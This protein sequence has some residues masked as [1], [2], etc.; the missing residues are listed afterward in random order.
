MITAWS[1]SRW[2]CYE[3]CPLKARFKFVDKL[4]EPGSP[5]MDRGTAI[6]QLAQDY[7]EGKV[8]LLPKELHPFK[9]DFRAL[10]KAHALCE[11]E[12][13]FTSSW[14]PTTWFG[15]DAWLR[16]K[17][18]VLVVEPATI[19]VIDHKT[20]KKYDDHQGQLSLYALA[21]MILYP[22]VS[23]VNTQLWYLDQ[24]D[25]LCQTYT[26]DALPK[27]KKEWIQKTKPML[28]DKKFAPR[29]GSHCRWC[30]FRKE[31]DGPCP[32]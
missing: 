5:A 17:T 18:D 1:Y 3:E 31:A 29:P 10:K 23:A 12:W 27:L 9:E 21:G 14:E 16:V 28:K 25:T 4:Q 11:L 24:R 32:L 22:E 26:I 15:I 7:T 19:T 30:Y 2:K 20:G 8:R 6:H 13:A